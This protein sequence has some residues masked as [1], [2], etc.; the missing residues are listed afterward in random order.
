MVSGIPTASGYEERIR[1][2]EMEVVDRGASEQGLVVNM[3]EGQAVNGW[4]INVAGVRQVTVKKKMRKTSHAEFIIRS[5]KNDGQEKFVGRRYGDFARL[6]K[7]LRTEIP[8]KV[9][10]PLP[11]KNRTHTTHVF[12]GGGG[13][14]DD[15]SDSSVSSQTST[16]TRNS[17]SVDDAT[18]GG[19]RSYIGLGSSHKRNPSSTSLSSAVSHGKTSPARTDSVDPQGDR[20][21]LYREEQRVSFRAFLRTLLQNERV[22]SSAAMEDFLTRSP[23]ELKR[24]EIEDIARRKEMDEKR[25]EE[26]RQFY[27]IARK[28]A[29]EL[30]VHMEKFRRDIVESSKSMIVEISITRD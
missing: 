18:G 1:F 11:R 4:D 8:G 20:I 14:D 5:R 29:K 2:S 24:E 21:V 3:P 16:P 6:H 13:G 30:D 15:E 28:R 19:F 7:Q 23:L 22:A 27:E 9:L 12:G 10:P 25:I 26:Q 17:L